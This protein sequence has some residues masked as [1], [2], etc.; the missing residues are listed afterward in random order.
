MP[1]DDDLIPNES[2]TN[3]T[4]GGSN[5]PIEVASEKA[6][7]D[8]HVEEVVLFPDNKG[9]ESTEKDFV[10]FDL[11]AVDEMEKPKE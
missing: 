6:L 9:T 11:D 8:R 7:H 4:D 1:L 5:T 10:K 3:M 2:T